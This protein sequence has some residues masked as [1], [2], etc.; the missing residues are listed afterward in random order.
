MRIRFAI[1]TGGGAR[2]AAQWP[3][4]RTEYLDAHCRN[5]SRDE[6]NTVCQWCAGRD[7]QLDDAHPCEPGNHHAK[8]L[9]KVAV[10]TTRRSGS[11]DDFRI[12]GTALS[13]QQVKQLAD[14][15]IVSAAAAATN[16]VTTTST[17]LSVLGND[18][19]AG[20]SALTYTWSASGTPPAP[21]NFS[22]NGTNAARNTVATFTQ[23]GT[24]NFQVTIDNPALGQT[25]AAISSVS[26]TVIP[27]LTTISVS[28][29]SANL[30]SGQMQ[31][32]TAVGLDQ[33]GNPLSA[34]PS[35]N[36]SLASG[37]VGMVDASGLYTAQNRQWAWPRFRPLAEW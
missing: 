24:Y 5:A 26:V 17:T 8:L 35:F 31:L 25:F 6:C 18:V 13:A 7:E 27:T 4:A 30:T 28:P 12:Y 37:S 23:Q 33:Y 2:T 10:P 9:R 14:P 11:I 21:V 1:T 16:P 29:P 20:E 36:W 3:I 34:P 19:T 15:A 22:V 32:F